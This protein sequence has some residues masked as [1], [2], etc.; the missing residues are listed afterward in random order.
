VELANEIDEIQSTG[1]Y[2]KIIDFIEREDT[3]H[4]QGIVILQIFND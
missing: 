4:F 3:G 1:F 2:A